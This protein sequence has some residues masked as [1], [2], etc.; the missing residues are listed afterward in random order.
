MSLCSGLGL[1]LPRLAGKPALEL[2]LRRRRLFTL[3]Y[4][5]SQDLFPFSPVIFDIIPAVPRLRIACLALQALRCM[6]ASQSLHSKSVRGNKIRPC[7]SPR[8]GMWEERGCRGAWDSSW[9]WPALPCK[10]PWTLGA[11]MIAK[12]KPRTGTKRLSAT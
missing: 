5:G 10:R 12:P 11:C 7:V 1:V 9:L 6:R 8:G 3:P 4:L 2:R